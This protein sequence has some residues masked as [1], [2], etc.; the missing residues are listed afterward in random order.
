MNKMVSIITP[1]HNSLEFLESTIS[2]V[3]SQTYEDWELLITDDCSTD[4]TW[5]YLQEIKKKDVRIKVFKL[6]KNSGPAL[7]RNNSIAQAQGRFIAFLDSDDTWTSE[8]LEKQIIFMLKYKYIFTFTE[9][10]MFDEYDKK[11]G[12]KEGLPVRVNYKKMLESNYIGCL[13]AIYDT[14]ILGKVYMPEIRKRQDYG[15]WLKILKKIDYAYCVKEPLAHYRVRT[16]SIS[17]NKLNLIKYNWILFREIERLSIWSSSL[18][19]MKNIINK[20]SK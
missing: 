6:E 1:T 7:A 16:S 2:S 8:K 4:G 19:L 11:I 3:L 14:E 18:Y 20:I 9:Y 17:S 13:T 15:L 10:M 5:E 12:I